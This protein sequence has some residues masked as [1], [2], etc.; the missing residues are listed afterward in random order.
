MKKSLKI[1]A[2][3]VILLGVVCIWGANKVEASTY[4]I[5]E[6]GN[7][8]S[9]SL[10]SIPDTINLDIKESEFQ[11]AALLIT[12]EAEK[13]LNKK[14]IVIKESQGIW[15][16]EKSMLVVWFG[17]YDDENGMDFYTDIHKANI[18]I[19]DADANTIDKKQVNV[20]Y[21][22]TD[23][24][25]EA[26]KKSVEELLA[27]FSISNSPTYKIVKK[28]KLGEYSDQTYFARRHLWTIFNDQSIKII[29]DGRH[30][31]QGSLLSSEVEIG[32]NIL[33]NDVFYQGIAVKVEQIYEIMVPNNIEKTEAE[34]IKYAKNE[35]NNYFE[36]QHNNEWE[37]ETDGTKYR[38]EYIVEEITRKS[39]NSNEY[40]VKVKYIDYENDNM[41]YY[42]YE[43]YNVIITSEYTLGD[44]NGDDKINTSDAR[45]VLLAYIGE[46]VLTP[47]EKLAADV[48]YDGQINTADVRRIL[49]YYIG[50]IGS[51]EY[52]Q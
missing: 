18:W 15:N 9:T 3:V 49:L 5:I 12:K 37:D 7:P 43:N 26:D 23:S 47:T 41:T 11:D 38:T 34:Y 17:D 4:S 27:K 48:N 29:E 30:A 35:L 50:V 45:K 39:N 28:L 2:I 20:K 33:K 42:D 36:A 52:G 51:F 21:S 10:D 44:L 25:N 13:E 31:G 24:H 6:S 16:A 14:G 22:N 40:N 46:E 19:H 8:D 32:F 1:L